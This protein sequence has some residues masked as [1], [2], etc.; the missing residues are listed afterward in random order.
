M[1]YSVSLLSHLV[2]VMVE[3]IHYGD[4]AIP[5]STSEVVIVAQTLQTFI[6]WP[7]YLLRLTSNSLVYIYTSI[8][9]YEI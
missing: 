1:L 6:V 5:L 3:K 8:I 4:F 2:K 9:T 7:K